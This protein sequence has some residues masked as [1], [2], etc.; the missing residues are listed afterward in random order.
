MIILSVN[1]IRSLLI[2]CLYDCGELLCKGSSTHKEPIDILLANEALSVSICNGAA[3]DQADG[4][5]DML[6]CNRSDPLPY[7]IMR[8]LCDFRGSSLACTDGPYWLVSN[9][10][11]GP[12]L[13]RRSHRV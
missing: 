9:D 2:N 3:I 10:N 6:S 13:D 4:L 1:S 5:S 7:E 8:L 11:L 12:V